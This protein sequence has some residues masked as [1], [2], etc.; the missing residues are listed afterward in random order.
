[1]GS[2]QW[3][4][5][6]H[7]FPTHSPSFQHQTVAISSYMWHIAAWIH[8]LESHVHLLHMER[9]HSKCQG[10]NRHTY[11]HIYTLNC[12]FYGS[13]SCLS[14]SPFCGMRH[15][16]YSN[17]FSVGDETCATFTSSSATV[18]LQVLKSHIPQL[19]HPKK[20]VGQENV[21]QTQQRHFRGKERSFTHE[22]GQSS[23]K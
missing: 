4:L 19:V 1:M 10:I 21:Q 11:I 7:N 15:S 12:S 22:L 9:E 17:W 16:L 20:S 14:L 6:S 5:S 2:Q 18:S 23:I 3:G 8:E 13:S